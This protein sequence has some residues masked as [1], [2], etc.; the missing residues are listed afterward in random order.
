MGLIFP[1]KKK[2]HKKICY[3]LWMQDSIMSQAMSFNLCSKWR[4][5]S[6]S[7]QCKSW[8]NDWRASNFQKRSSEVEQP[9]L[10]KWMII[11]N[12]L[13]LF[14]K[15]LNIRALSSPFDLPFL[16]LKSFVNRLCYARFHQINI[17]NDLWSERIAQMLMK[18][19]VLQI[20]CKYVKSKIN[21]K[22]F[23]F[24]QGKFKIPSILR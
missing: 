3:Y 15:C 7:G 2:F 1:R 24:L 17:S 9:F 19:P 16:L 6:A 8:I 11:V 14:K 22:D 5:N 13:A 23:K 12:N 10:Y 21:L 20:I 18:P 4:A